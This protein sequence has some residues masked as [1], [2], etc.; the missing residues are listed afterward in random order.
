MLVNKVQ[1]L[2]IQKQD[3]RSL[4]AIETKAA[5]RK[6][7]ARSWDR[8]VVSRL[9]AWHMAFS[10]LFQTGSGWVYW[11][12][13]TWFKRRGC[14]FCPNGRTLQLSVIWQPGCARG[15][16]KGPLCST[17]YTVISFHRA[18]SPRAMSRE[19][20]SMKP[21]VS[22]FPGLPSISLDISCP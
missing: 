19:V 1:Y 8:D 2:G 11:L 9:P 6:A 16:R 13:T 22:S 3:R 15:W 10:A 17:T 4:G 18:K 12:E 21:L 14:R 20:T 7:F 5:F